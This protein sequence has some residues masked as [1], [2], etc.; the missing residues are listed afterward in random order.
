MRISADEAEKRKPPPG[1]DE[2]PFRRVLLLVAGILGLAALLFFTAGRIDWW[3]GWVY[4]GYWLTMLATTLTLMAKKNPGLIEAR[5]RR[6]ADT[7]PSDRIILA[8]YSPLPLA[9]LVTAGLDTRFGWGTLSSAWFPLGLGL[10]VLGSIPSAWA[11]SVNPH[12]EATVRI[13]NDRGHRVVSSGPY[14]FLRHPGYLSV[15]LTSTGTPLLLGSSWAF[16]PVAAIA[17]IITL[18][19]ALEDRT[20]RRELPGYQEYAQRVRWR[21]FPG[22]W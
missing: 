11:V 6:H 20:L 1:K 18:R 8:V 5:R 22:I 9:M 16:V 2:L 17:G 10:L 4:L 19:T 3:Q 14:R 15:I 13:Q 7:K 21:L 12:F